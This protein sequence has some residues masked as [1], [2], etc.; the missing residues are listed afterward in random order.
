LGVNLPSL[1]IFSANHNASSRRARG[2]RFRLLLADFVVKAIGW[3]VVEFS[4]GR[5]MPLNPERRRSSA[6]DDLQELRRQDETRRIADL[7]HSSDGPSWLA[8]AEIRVSRTE[9]RF[10]AYLNRLLQQNQP[11]SESLTSLFPVGLALSQNKTRL[12]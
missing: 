4:K 8:P 1:S 9:S 11:C 3:L 5:L 2:Y 12:P 7:G 6:L 10:A